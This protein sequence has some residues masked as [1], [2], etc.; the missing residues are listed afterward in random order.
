MHVDTK[1]VRILIL[2]KDRS[3]LQNNSGFGDTLKRHIY[4]AKR[5][6]AYAANSE[7]QIITYSSRKQNQQKLFPE[8]GISI[9]GTNS[10]H[11][12]LFLFDAYKA[13]KKIT[14]TGWI[15][16]VITTQD[17][18]ED[19]QLGLWLAKK[20][21]AQ[22]IPQLH[23]D[24][25]SK[26]WLKESLLNYPRK[27]IASIV[28]KKASAI[29]VVSQTQKNK[30]IDRF[31][32]NSNNIYVVPVGVSFLPT[33]TS[34]KICKERIVVDPSNKVVLFVGRLY[35][36]KNMFLWVDVAKDIIKK[37]ENV[38]FIIAGGGVLS[39]KI[40]SYVAMQELS[41]YF[42]FLGDVSY[43]DLPDIYGAADAFLLTS[44]YEG[45]GRV[46]VEANLAGIPVVSTKCTGPEDI[47]QDGET[48]Y[49]CDMDDKKC[50]SSRVLKLLNNEKQQEISLRAK[51]HVGRLFNRTYLADLLVKLWLK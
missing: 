20:Y 22:F 2:S 29:R 43:D 40:I 18:Y 23:F 27:F 5:L 12:A 46:I 7:I 15:P 24:L 33:A 25:F 8:D 26:D 47:I 21:K 38:R 31:G 36:P 34:K 14:N 9:I 6:K 51:E 16:T 39:D 17:P 13:I 10:K 44:Y 41:N 30:L 1:Q 49:L 11:R 42:I 4:Y 37:Q 3:F 32:L 48:G 45:F 35:P 28:L 19:G 50:L